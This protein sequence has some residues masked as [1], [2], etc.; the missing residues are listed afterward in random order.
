[1]NTKTILEDEKPFYQRTRRLAIAEKE[2]LDKQLSQWLKDGIIR[3]SWSDFASPIVIVRKKE[4]V[5]II[6]RFVCMYVGR[7]V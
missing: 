7:R 2:E 1:M 6:G 4:S 3:H 5:P